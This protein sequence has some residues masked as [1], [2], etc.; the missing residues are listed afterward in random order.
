MYFGKLV[1]PHAPI[2]VVVQGYGFSYA[3]HARGVVQQVVGNDTVVQVIVGVIVAAIVEYDSTAYF[4]QIDEVL[5]YVIAYLRVVF[6]L[7]CRF[8]VG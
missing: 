8:Q 7:L 4:E 6:R 5:G 1:L 3:L 2:R